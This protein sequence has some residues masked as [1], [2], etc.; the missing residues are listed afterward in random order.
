VAISALIGANLGQ[1]GGDQVPWAVIL[2]KFR[3]KFHGAG[4]ALWK[5]WRG[6]NDPEAP[7]TVSSRFPYE[8]PPAE[9]APGSVALPDGGHVRSVPVVTAATGSASADTASASPPDPALAP[10]ASTAGPVS[11]EGDAA[12][13]GQLFPVV[14]GGVPH[15]CLRPI[16]HLPVPKSAAPWTC[17]SV[18]SGRRER[19]RSPVCAARP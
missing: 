19:E 18:A 17:R 4:T 11:A 3:E 16:R 14:S 5:D 10:G 12:S 8:Q 15:G 13:R 1:G 9:L 2:Q 6:R 7:T